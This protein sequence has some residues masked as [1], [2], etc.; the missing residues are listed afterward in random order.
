MVVH[1]DAQF[2]FAPEVLF[3][4][5]DADVSEEELNLLQFASRNVAQTRAC[6]PQI[7]RSK[8]AELSFP[9][10]LL[11]NAPDH[12]FR[13]MWF[14]ETR[15]VSNLASMQAKADGIFARSSRLIADEVANITCGGAGAESGSCTGTYCCCR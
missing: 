14:S 15:L 2:L 8:V 4:R 7:V 6:A 1:R 13:D 5:L 3:G 10:K 9:G 11:N 12:L